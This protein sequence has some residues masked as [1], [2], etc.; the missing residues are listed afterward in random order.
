MALLTINYLSRA[1]NMQVDVN[2]ILPESWQN[3][4]AKG[5]CDHKYPVLWLLHGGGGDHTDWVRQTAIER[6]ASEKGLAVVMPGVDSSG[7][8]DMKN[9]GYK[10]FT[11][12][13][14]DLPSFLS[15]ILPLSTK[16]EDNFVAGLSMGGYG[17]TKM[18]LHHP[19]R[20]AACGSFSGAIDMVYIL[21]G[22]ET[23]KDRAIGGMGLCY[24]GSKGIENTPDDNMYMFEKL[25]KEGVELPKYY[26]AIGNDDFGYENNIQAMDRLKEMGVE[27]E[28]TPD[29]GVHNWAFWDRHI[30]KFLD[31]I[32]LAANEKE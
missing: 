7:Y 17:S 4:L 12:V 14:E 20:F 1:L 19:E 23:G 3:N 18:M 31:W 10:Y 8:M 16:K 22:Q 15:N 32:P 27:F 9:G 11:F 13:S 5:I 6:Y 25:T 30:Q 29:E 21:R 26:I 28:Y 24:G 2:V